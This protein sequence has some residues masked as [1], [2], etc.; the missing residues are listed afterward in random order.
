[1]GR[2]QSKRAIR[3]SSDGSFPIETGRPAGFGWGVS[4]RNRPSVGLRMGRFQS[5]RARAGLGVRI[6][7]VPESRPSF[8]PP[9]RLP[10]TLAE[11][12]EPEP[13]PEAAFLVKDPSGR[14]V[15]V[16]Q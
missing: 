13:V 1:M 9:L 2:F 10:E 11:L 14:F 5:K 12:F 4:T 7:R 6:T 15:A 3:R 16:N 8:V